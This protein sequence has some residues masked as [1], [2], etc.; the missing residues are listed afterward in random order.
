MGKGEIIE[1]DNSKVKGRKNKEKEATVLLLCLTSILQPVWLGRPYKEYET[2]ASIAIQVMRYAIPHHE[3]VTA[4]V[5]RYFR[6]YR[7]T[8]KITLRTLLF[9]CCCC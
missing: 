4:H 3:K 2:P 7:C 8:N 5:G 9:F 1:N 6:L